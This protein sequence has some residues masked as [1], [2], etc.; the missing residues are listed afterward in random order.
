MKNTEVPIIEI[1]D[2]QIFF[3]KSA[4]AKL[5]KLEPFAWSHWIR[6]YLF[7]SSYQFHP[8]SRPEP[9]MAQLPQMFSRKNWKTSFFNEDQ[10]VELVIR[11]FSDKLL[12]SLVSSLQSSA[13]SLT[14]SLTPLF[15]SA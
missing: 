1:F 13:S 12:S 3:E 7:Y 10:K 14:S 8:R 9:E 2:S 11:L 5:L 4:K 6:K 15:S